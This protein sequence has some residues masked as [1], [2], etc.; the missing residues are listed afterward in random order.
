MKVPDCDCIYISKIEKIMKVYFLKL[1]LILCY[2]ENENIWREDDIVLQA[3]YCPQC[4]TK[5]KEAKD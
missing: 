5:Y 4:G 1:K 3:N 2:K